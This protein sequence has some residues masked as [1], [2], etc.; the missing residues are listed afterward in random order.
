LL[1]FRNIW[2]SFGGR[3]VLRD[4][5]LEAERGRI[6][7]IIGPN[8]SGKSTML[9]IA[10]LLEVPDRGEASFDGDNILD[11]GPND[12]IDYRRKMA[13]VFQQP[14][15]YNASV[16]DNV[17]MG[18]RIRGID[19]QLTR[20]RVEEA[21]KAVN[22]YDLRDARAHSLSGGEAQRLCL[23]G[24]LVVKPEGLLLDEP[25]ANLD[26]ANAIIVEKIVK[27][28]ASEKK[29]IVVFTTHNMFEAKRLADRVL[30]LIEGRVIEEGAAVEVLVKP[31]ED[32]TARF[33]RGEMIF[34]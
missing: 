15:L 13:M 30:L 7:C 9:R 27:E 32:M 23:A 24:A 21:L 1:R 12:R 22:L 29:G 33:L 20:E 19:K 11:L 18:M 10:D 8:G 28:Y 17:A 16:Y 3:E 5:C 14:V 26:P 25:T 4:V 34:G 2:K 31:K 6:S